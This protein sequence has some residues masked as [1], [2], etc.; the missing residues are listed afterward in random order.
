[1]IEL[2]LWLAI[3]YLLGGVGWSFFHPELQQRIES[4]W[5]TRLPAGSEV[6]AFGATTAFWPVFVVGADVCQE[7]G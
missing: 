4:D 6:F 1:M 2:A 3:P 7:P 5:E